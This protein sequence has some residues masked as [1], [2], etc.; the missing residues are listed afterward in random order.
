MDEAKL[1]DYL[2]RVT[3]DLHQTRLRLQEMEAGEH[4]PIA[5]IGMSCRYPGDV[6]SV[7]DLWRL[8]SAGE[9]A[10]GEFPDDRGWDL[11]TLFGGSDTREGGFVYDAGDFD[12]AFFGISPREATAMDPQQRLLLE[13]SWEAIERA[14][15]DPTSLRGSQT[16][17]FAGTAGQDYG[18]LLLGASEGLEGHL[19]TGNAAA[20]VSGRVSYSLGLEGPAVTVDTACSSSLVAT[21]L[22]CQALRQRECT[23]ALAGGAT[24]MAT[25]GAFLEFSRQKGLAGDGRC[26]A[27]AA[28]A[29]GTGWS[30]GAGVLVLE[31]LSD[32]QRNGHTILAVIRGSAVNQDGA[33]NGLSAPNGPAQQRVIQRAL[34]NAG[35]TPDQVHAVEAHGTGTRLGDPIEAQALID[36]YGQNRD[37]PL[38]L[39]SIKSN[40]GHTQ[41]AAGVA[42]IIKMVLAMRHGVL[43]ETLH[44]DEPTPHVDWTAGA[45]RLLTEARPWPEDG[46]PRRS[47]VSSFGVSGTNAHIVL[48][49]GQTALSAGSREPARDAPSSGAPTARSLTSGG[50]PA[51]EDAAAGADSTLAE[52]P[53]VPRPRVP[54]DAGSLP[55]PGARAAAGP[56]SEPGEGA[57]T[58]HEPAHSSGTPENAPEQGI[59]AA[60]RIVPWVVSGKTEAALRAQAVHLLGALTALDP[61]D[62][63]YS[64]ATTRTAFEH[65]AVVLGGDQAELIGGLGALAEGRPHPG[66]VVG[67]KSAGQVAFLF[68]GQGSQRPGMG[69]ELCAAFPVFGETFNAVTQALDVHLDR[70]LREAVAGDEVHQTVY[71]QAGLFA[72]EVAMFRLVSSWGITADHLIGHSIGELAAAHV[73]GVLSLEDA[74]ALVAARGRLMQALPQGGAMIAVQATEE[75]VLGALVGD[76]EVAVAAI[77]APGSVVLSGPEDATAE[78]AAWFADQGRK[79]RRLT[80]SHAFHSPLMEPML[81]DF[82]A[83]AESLT[84]HEPA[85]SIVSNL[86]GQRIT[87]FDAS[88]WVRHVRDAVRFADGIETLNTMGVT[89]FVE[90]GPDGVL[91]AMGQECAPERTFLATQRKGRLEPFTLMTALAGLHANG[92]SPDWNAIFPGATRADLPTYAF[93]RERFWP[94]LSRRWAGDLTAVG[95]RAAD[96]PLL[97]AAVTLADA[98]GLLFTGRMSL[99]THPWLADH[100]V[101]GTVLLPGTAF[102]DLS[103]RAGAQAGTP[104]VKELTLQSPLILPDRADAELQVAVGSPDEYGERPVTIHSRLDADGPW[105]RNAT[106]ILAT[107]TADDSAW[108]MPAS[109]PPAGATPISLEGFYE[110]LAAHGFTYGASFQGLRAGWV[111][112]GAA[113]AEIALPEGEGGDPAAFCL[114]PALLDAAMHATG[115]LPPVAAAEEGNRLPFAWNEVTLHAAGAASLRVRVTRSATGEVSVTAAAPDGTPV[116]TVKSLVLRAISPEQLVTPQSDDTL[117]HVEWTPVRPISTIPADRIAD[118]SEVSLH[119]EAMTGAHAVRATSEAAGFAHVQA[120]GKEVI[121]STPIPDFVLAR[122]AGDDPQ[123][124]ARDALHL[125]QSWLAEERFSRSRL[126]FVTEDALAATVADNVSGLAAATVWG[127]IRSAQSEN[128]DRFILIDFDGTEASRA[129]LPAA[130]AT[131]EPQL[132]LRDGTFRVPRLTRTSMEPALAESVLAMPVPIAPTQTV[133]AFAGAARMEVASVRSAGLGDSSTGPAGPGPASAGSAGFEDGPAGLAGPGDIS[134]GSTPDGAASAGSARTGGTATEPAGLGGTPTGPARPGIASAGSAGFEDG[135]AGPGDISAGSA[136][137]GTAS[138]GSARTGDTPTEPAGP[139]A[140]SSGPARSGIVRA[141]SARTGADL[142][143]PTRIGPATSGPATSGP[144]ATA[145]APAVSAE[146]ADGTILLTGATGTLGRL[147]AKHL[148][149][150]HGARRLLLTSRRGPDAPGADELVDELTAAGAQV[151]LAA[152]DTADRDALAALLAGIPAAHPLSAVIHAAGVSDDGVITSLTPER[153]AVVLRP[154]VDAARH[155]HELTRHADLRAFVMFSSLAATLGG[156]G[157]GNYAAANAYLDA[158]AQHRA[159]EGLPATSLVWGLWQARSGM[160][161]HLGDD[162]FDRIA[163]GGVVAMDADEALSLFDRALASGR[164]VVA[165]ARLDMVALRAQAA[166]GAVPPLLRGLVK[167]PVRRAATASSAAFL[168]HLTTLQDGER[169]KAVLDLVRGQVAAVLG[170]TGIESIEPRKAFSELGVDSLTA[171]EIRNQLGGATGLRLPATLV[172]DYPTPHAL[173][174]HVDAELAGVTPAV[175]ASSA[176]P[177]TLE[178]RHADA[179]DPVVI[180]GMACRYPGGV[181]TPEDLWNLVAQGRDGVGP[182][183][184][185][186]G[187]DIDGLYDPDGSRAGGF[188]VREGGFIEGADRFDA[189]FFGI[190]PREAVAMDPQQRQLLEVSWEAVERAGINPHT[191]RGSRTGVFA[192]TSGQDYG[193]VLQR[194][195]ASIGGYGLTS[196]TASVISGRVSYTLGLEGPSVS[197]DTACSSSLVALHLAAQSLRQEECS[198]ALVGG[199]MVMSTPA[200]FVAF[201]SQRG[202]AADGRCKAFSESADGI[203][204]SEGVGVLVLERLSDARRNG[205]RVLAVVRGSAINQDGASNG[206]TAPNG[207]SQQRVI[208]QALSSGG[209]SPADVD[210]VEAHGTGTTLGD[211]IEAQ[212]LLATYGRDRVEPLQLGSI[213]SNI[214]HSQAAAGVAGVIKSVLAMRHGVMPETLHIDEPSSHVDWGSGA[215]E[216]LTSARAW[217]ELTR[218]RRAAV[219]SFG[220]SGTNAHVIVEAPPLED[221]DLVTSSGAM[222]AGGAA[223]GA[224]S[225]THIIPGA[226][227]GSGSGERV[228]GPVVW[229]VSGRSAEAL[230]AAAGRVAAVCADLD[231][232]DVGWSLAR[233]RSVF[234]H[235]AVAVGRSA[236]ALAAGLRGLANDDASPAV[237]AGFAQGEIDPVFVFPGQGW[238]WAGMAEGLLAGSPVFAARMAECEAALAPFVELGDDECVEVLQPR[239]WAVMVSLAAVWESLGVRPAAV[240]GHSQGEIAAAVVAGALSLED[241]ARVV[242]LRSRALA[243]ICGRGGMVAVAL[244]E[245][246]VRER[247]ASRQSTVVG[248]SLAA[249]PVTRSGGEV[250][251]TGS[252]TPGSTTQGSTDLVSTVSASGLRPGSVDASLSVDV[253]QAPL[254]VG[255][256]SVAA[257]NGPNATVVAGDEAALEAFRAECEADGIRARRIP[258]D[259]ASH[260]SHVEVLESQIVEALHPIRPKQSRIPL[261]STVTGETIDT[262]TMDATYWYRNLRRP[263]LF[264]QAV[265]NAPSR[266]FIEVSAHPVLVPGIDNAT[267]IGTLRRDEGGLDRLALSAAEAHVN[268]VQVDF[269]P[270]NAGGRIV[271]LPTY[272]FEQHRFWV[273]AP[274]ILP[275][276]VTSAGLTPAGHPMLGAAIPLPDGDGVL[277]TGRLSTRTHPWLGEHK[278]MGANVMPGTAFVELAMYAAGHV[279]CSTLE[280]LTLFV[281]LVVPE[282]GARAI[283]LAVSAP[284]GDGHRTIILRSRA[285]DGRVV[286]ERAQD[287]STE[288]GR[289]LDGRADWVHHASGIL[290]DAPAAPAADLTVWPPPGASPMDLSA[291]YDSVA[292]TVFDYG[293]MFQGLTAAWA[294]GDEVYAELVLPEAARAEAGTYGMHPALLDA[295]LQAMSLGGFLANM[296]DGEPAERSRLPFV[297]SGVTLHATGASTMRV[298]LAPTSSVGVSFTVADATGAP[299]AEI[300]SLIMRPVSADQLSTA[301]GTTIDSLYTLTWTPV[302]L[303]KSATG[304]GRDLAGQ[305]RTDAHSDGIS[306]HQDVAAQG[307]DSPL[308]TAEVAIIGPDP[309]GLAIAIPARTARNLSSLQETPPTVLLSLTSMDDLPAGEAAREAVHIALEL[310]QTW[311]ADPAHHHA[312]LAIITNGA[313]AATPGEDVTDLENAAV[314]GLIRSAQSEHPGRFVLID[315]DGA[316]ESIANILQ[317]ATG[318]EPQVA[319]RQGTPLAPRLAT[320]PMPST[321]T[322]L[323]TGTILI[324][325]GTGTLG[326][327]LARHLASAHAAK[328]LLLASRGGR[329]DDELAEALR[330]HGAEVT[331]AACD[332][333]DRDALAELIR[334]IPDE[335]PLTA[336]VHAAGALDDGVITSLTP[337]QIDTVLRPKTDAAWNLHE[338][339]R[340]HDLSAFV[341]FSSASGVFGGA[342]QSDYAAAN[343]FLDALAAHRRAA[344]LPAVSL[345]WGLWAQASGMTGHLGDDGTR[346]VARG[347]V[348]PL[349]TAKALE[350]FDA[351][352]SV[353]AALLVP[354]DLDLAQLRAQGDPPPLLRTL[355]RPKPRKAAAGPEPGSTTLA[356]RLATL[357]EEERDLLILQV[358]RAHVAAVLGYGTA[359]DVE[360][361]RSFKELGFDSLTAVE[362]RNRLNVATGL[363]LPATLAFD[364]PTPVALAAHLRTEITPDEAAAVEPVLADLGRLATTIGVL[365]LDEAARAQIAAKLRDVLAALGSE[366]VA[367]DLE[368]ATDDE[369]FEFISREF[370]VS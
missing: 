144:T 2:K 148:V 43:P 117:F 27:F 151:E 23:I 127:L 308:A 156:G 91:T 346:R 14:G 279:G 252:T 242:A 158:L 251:G 331:V 205:H 187:W 38:W 223:A 359:D 40:L 193:G 344:G 294:R 51:S 102:V 134:A 338:L 119:G 226:G 109:W 166:F 295:G 275:A 360:A 266:V 53:H 167:A 189:A 161:E 107:E 211:P 248:G 247:L 315:H 239:L 92:V 3:A 58:G 351:A 155:L 330:A 71:T 235:R 366:S 16:G 267:G 110:G 204:W 165:P 25:P 354:A 7:E 263:V 122:L 292:R 272:P 72:F 128:P 314:W 50:M 182:I 222:V 49:Q 219:S 228:G 33:S 237:V 322:S 5:I 30:E 311:L 320:S 137:T 188:Y 171:V 364:Y 217:P 336:V 124:L 101:R 20:V 8:L 350:L 174:V 352:L 86:T 142:A 284:D 80:V 175:P 309:F 9:D 112:D 173:A 257:V 15:I 21:H 293:P 362:L 62:A 65:R 271:D 269:E 121:G 88:H 56:E 297:W 108:T 24:V 184:A 164:P 135:S 265:T 149:E 55:E 126:V 150:A 231:P 172:F 368:T 97:G 281:P 218:P 213:K 66:V 82:R 326:G 268:G 306:G 250:E 75:E 260:C 305:V 35:L 12:A 273:D 41:A 93:Q 262:A 145:F 77:N 129:A 348:R 106:G 327:L 197:V 64:L 283:Q 261:I 229:A 298:R 224:R 318:Q 202:L 363:R 48:E 63:G 370:G 285:D 208:M 39:G 13:V 67:R 89:R 26:K 19:L 209:L 225:A 118:L 278:V 296:G 333:A 201:S 168:Q 340:D 123:A 136:P 113:Y 186:R 236:G 317:A 79:T 254:M 356:Q 332:A 190:S 37:E 299:I 68:S 321:S 132:A 114:H 329:I 367:D 234:E 10:L 159:A 17:V 194:D 325:G 18:T 74:A 258:V 253:G 291:F 36:T 343:T 210:L 277:F 90:L 31:R 96:H 130:L 22:A 169:F 339:T 220:V 198:L 160:S 146:A 335:H 357:P 347:G 59:P 215:V 141:G 116:A 233:A 133:A 81:A 289:A 341:L 84:Y 1:L 221:G 274:A 70:P 200:A 355:I 99:R 313:V 46:R 227:S 256:L 334:T 243:E 238:Q 105:T 246:E 34:A 365:P 44:I 73:A 300:E 230:R 42:G 60:R 152:C 324:T 176:A 111:K 29:D 282:E 140:P 280:E 98:E 191:L 319:L 185:D 241:G 249:G 342:G 180:V 349:A 307:A 69:E 87:S 328:H 103:L 157:Q 179:D 345:A 207:P 369:M 45:V 216:L 54:A 203:G 85:I 255:G 195:P 120:T 104:R 301:G 286:D 259:Y 316:P 6:H 310:A 52:G 264:D 244:S 76:A 270:F 232:V 245:A 154:K 61:A 143:G 83:V 337:D 323:E 287:G 353:D 288:D 11:E 199:V 361:T 290:T 153:L 162:H 192:G 302:V 95:V 78:L 163:R 57:A 94:D 47:A 240:I 214:G 115:L 28:S 196:T 206:L 177:Y 312:K 181:R 147:L 304:S 178:A 358:I 170:H 303:A 139:G 138:A 125:A 100:A 4:E 183:P 212:A 131:G 32:A 276:D